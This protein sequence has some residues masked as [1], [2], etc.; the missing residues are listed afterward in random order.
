MEIDTSQ[1]PVMQEGQE[2]VDKIKRDKNHGRDETGT[3]LMSIQGLKA[4]F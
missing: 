1:N 3:G 2:K 4:L